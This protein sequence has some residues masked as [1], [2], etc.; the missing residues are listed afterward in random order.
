MQSMRATFTLTALIYRNEAEIG[1]ALKEKFDDGSITRKDIEG[2]VI[3][4]GSNSLIQIN[5]SNNL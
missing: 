2:N 5:Y 1:T 3:I 4:T